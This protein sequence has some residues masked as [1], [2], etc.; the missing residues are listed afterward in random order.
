MHACG[1]LYLVA[2]EHAQEA[3]AWVERHRQ[4]EYPI[5]S[6]APRDLTR[7]GFLRSDH[8]GMGIFE[9]RGGYGDPRLTTRNLAAGAQQNGALLFEHCAVRSIGRGADNLWSL[10]FEQGH[11]QC[12]CLVVAGG[13]YAAELLPELPL[14]VQSI[15]LTQCHIK[16]QMVPFP[17]IDECSQTFLRPI[18]GGNVWCGGQAR[19]VGNHPDKL[20]GYGRPQLEDAQRRAAMLL[21]CDAHIA[22][23][24]GVCGFDGYTR[25]Y[26][27]IIGFTDIA[28]SLYVAAGFSGRGYKYVLPVAEA[29]AN[30]I[31]GRNTQLDLSAFRPKPLCAQI[32]ATTAGN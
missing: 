17:V 6:I 18:G 2:P 26:R 20:A 16:N 29:I 19:A 25:D 22:P 24:T 3:N 11:V 30:D 5:E 23:L 13:A 28:E 7:F 21:H 32:F 4:D 27:P 31:L 12:E 1:C 8:P 15:P 14:S 10:E 9:R